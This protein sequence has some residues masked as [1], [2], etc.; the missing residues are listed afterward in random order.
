MENAEAVLLN[1]TIIGV[2]ATA[3]MDLWAVLQKR[4]FGIPSLDYR[5]VGR[6]L[7]HIP[8]GR[9]HHDN[10]FAAPPVWGERLLGWAAHYAIGVAFAGLLLWVW[11]LEWAHAPGLPPALIVGVTTVAAPFLVL[12]PALGMG[13][14][15]S[16]TPRPNAARLKSV[17]THLC[18]GLGLY[19]AAEARLLFVG[20]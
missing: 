13:F 12:Q 1:A 3:V 16:R 8:S 10:I 18:F 2:G 19:L 9:V 17:F 5:L 15:A 7:G 11:G 4:G 20:G 14:A 6:W